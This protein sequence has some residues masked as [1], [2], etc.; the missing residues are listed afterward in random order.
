[1][2]KNKKV[3]II[4]EELTP[5]TLAIKADSKKSSI[6]GIIWL[7]IIFAIFIGG[8]IFLPDIALYVNNYLNPEPTTTTTKK[9]VEG[10]K[11]DE[12]EKEEI[13]EYNLSENP[14]I[15]TDE[16][17]LENI[18]IS[19]S[20]I[21]LEVLN[22]TDKILELNNLNYFLNLYDGSK[23][24][25]QRIYLNEGIIGASVR[26]T[27]SFDLKNI[28]VSILTITKITKEEYPVYNV[29]ENSDGAFIL[30][31][32]KG[33]ESVLYYLENNKVYAITDTFEVPSDDENYAL[34][35]SNYQALA[36]TYNNIGGVSSSVVVENNI[37]NFRTNINLNTFSIGAINN[38]IIYA[39][40][41]DA[42]IIKF[43]LEASNFT[44]K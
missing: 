34:L 41:T 27:L 44:C 42:K 29:K 23:K 20:K 9:P 6:F 10:N 19:D 1:M 30:E 17:I 32:S 8:V 14:K 11:P 40:D 3:V 37:M 24:L 22:N 5:T 13:T 4:D 18:K 7:I 33:F 26:E 43:E 2:A 36:T 15:E 31:C 12:T 28:N 35:Y 39:K 16:F 25:L 21:T 38:K